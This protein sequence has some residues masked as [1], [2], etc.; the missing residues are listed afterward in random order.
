MDLGPSSF[1]VTLNPS[2]FMDYSFSPN[3]IAPDA[4]SLPEGGD[5][6]LSDT[7]S[8]MPDLI[9]WPVLC[10]LI[11]D[12]N[13]IKISSGGSGLSTDGE[14]V[15]YLPVAEP[16]PPNSVALPTEMKNTI[17]EIGLQLQYPHDARSVTACRTAVM[18]LS[19]SSRA[20]ILD[21]PEFWTQF[22]VDTSTLPALQANLVY[23]RDK[24]LFITVALPNYHRVTHSSRALHSEYCIQFTA[25]AIEQVHPLMHRCSGLILEGDTRYTV[26][27]MLSSFELVTPYTLEYFGLR[28]HFRQLDDLSD[29]TFDFFSFDNWPPGQ[30]GSDDDSDTSSLSSAESPTTSS[31]SDQIASPRRIFPKAPF[32]TYRALHIVPSENRYSTCTHLTGSSATCIIEQSV[33]MPFR[34]AQILDIL[35][36]NVGYRS[37]VFRDVKFKSVR[38][39]I[40]ESPPFATVTSLDLAFCSN[41]SMGCLVASLNLPC[42]AYLTLRFNRGRDLDRVAES[43]SH[44]TNVQLVTRLIMEN[45]PVRSRHLFEPQSL[46]RLFTLLR[47]ARRI[48]MRSGGPSFLPALMIASTARAGV[49]TDNW[50]ACPALTH[51]DLYY[52]T[53]SDLDH[54]IGVRFASGYRPIKTVSVRFGLDK[55]DEA[56]VTKWCAQYGVEVGDFIGS[57]TEICGLKI[58]PYADDW[59]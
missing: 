51:L 6:S 46:S 31:P 5:S 9:D 14:V 36:P 43:S 23:A 24:P 21:R 16:F 8:D 52:A 47:R 34:W 48:D 10:S 28:F 15:D 11:G 7:P 29:N 33:K 49:L 59:H 56:F 42:L 44:L 1:S 50:Y 58:V 40:D 3:H 13:S 32:R 53:Y 22:L 35:S 27:T 26:G 45:Q 20:Y 37:L 41:G 54:L 18:N 12:T 17:F 55:L 38:A 19:H 57:W 25:A 2:D 39:D 4:E 30:E